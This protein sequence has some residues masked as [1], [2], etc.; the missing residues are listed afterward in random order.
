MH[1]RLATKARAYC[2]GDRVSESSGNHS[3]LEQKIARAMCQVLFKCE[4]LKD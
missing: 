3:F 2:S 4:L 1:T